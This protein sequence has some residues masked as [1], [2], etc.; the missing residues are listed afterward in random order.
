MKETDSLRQNKLFDYFQ[1]FSVTN[2]DTPARSSHGRASGKAPARPKN[3]LVP[4]AHGSDRGPFWWRRDGGAELAEHRE[5]SG[6]MSSVAG[7]LNTISAKV[8]AILVPFL[9]AVLILALIKEYSTPAAWTN[10]D[11]PATA[12]LGDG[13]QV[14]PTPE[15]PKPDLQEAPPVADSEVSPII[16]PQIEDTV[17][18]K[19]EQEAPV[20]VEQEKPVDEADAIEAASAESLI[21]EPKVEFDEITVKGILYSRDNP[22]AIIGD[23]IVHVGDVVLEATVVGIT[24]DTVLFEKPG[25]RWSCNV[26][27]AV[28]TP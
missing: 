19:V 5:V 18:A 27:E 14:E 20:Q 2:G 16:E 23:R 13:T 28:A 7:D 12:G 9:L 17:I 15:T 26:Q 25:Q 3:P 8:T 22:T 11:Q 21:A 24:K 1:D 4:P 10:A 6:R